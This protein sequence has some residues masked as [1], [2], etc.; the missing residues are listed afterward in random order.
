MWKSG[1]DQRRNLV[2]LILV[3][4]FGVGANANVA[5]GAEPDAV[6][7]AKELIVAFQKPDYVKWATY[8]ADDAVIEDLGSG[9][10]GIQLK[11]KK[12]ILAWLKICAE[13]W[14]D[15]TYKPLRII[16]QGNSV[17]WEWQW[18]GTQTKEFVD[19]LG[20]GRKVKFRGVTIWDFE[21]GKIKRE[22]TVFNYSTLLHQLDGVKQ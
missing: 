11:G 3:V 9:K 18:E 8:Y 6:A 21:N 4:L 13:S 20:A 12:E 2:L 22:V 16:A 15:A 14:S 17:L 1:K 5:A 10:E 7:I 19:A